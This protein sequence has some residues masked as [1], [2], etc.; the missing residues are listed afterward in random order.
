MD[1][2]ADEKLHLESMEDWYKVTVRDL[3]A[4]GGSPLMRYYDDSLFKLLQNIYP[5]YPW[6]PFR[7]RNI[8]VGWWKVPSNARQCLDWLGTKLGIEKLDDWYSVTY[9]QLDAFGM[10]YAMKIY[11]G[12]YKVSLP[13]HVIDISPVDSSQLNSIRSRK[14]NLIHPSI[15]HNSNILWVL[16]HNIWV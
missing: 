13:L 11:G 6:Q 3:S 16:L 9:Y 12:F 8:P 7:F 4:L 10:A 15:E 2:V 1:W 14:A 5:E